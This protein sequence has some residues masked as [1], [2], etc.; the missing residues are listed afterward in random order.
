MTPTSLR[1]PPAMH[2]LRV[3]LPLLVAAGASVRA[4]DRPNFL[5]I[6]ADDCTYSDL[7]LYGGG[8]ARTPNLDRLAAG[9]LTFDRAYVSS[10][11]CQ[12]CRSELYSGQ[13]PLRNGAAWN[14]SASR[15]GTLSLPHFLRPLGYRVGL[16]G[17]S[18]V[19]PKQAFPFDEVPGFDG[20]CVRN[21]TR[22]HELSG[23][24]DYMSPEKHDSPFCLVVALVEPHVPWVMGDASAYPPA[25]LKLPPHLADTPETRDNFSRYLAEVS[26]MDGQLGEIL[27]VLEAS[28]VADDT[29]VLFSSEQG[30]Q[31][32]GCKWTNWEA[33]V[34]TALVARWPGKV[35]TG[36]RSP[37]LVQYADLAP[38][39]VELAG[40]RPAAE[41]F[42]GSSF[43]EVLRGGRE[44]HRDYAYSMHNNLPEG[45]SYP[46]RSL[47]DGRFRYI[48]NLAPEALYVE[49]HVMGPGKEHNSYWHSWLGANPLTQPRVCELARRYMTRP[50]EQ[51]Y[52]LDADP[53]NLH[54][55][56]D[57]KDHAGDKE[58]LSAAL[59]AW[60]ESQRDP[61]APVDTPRALRAARQ[62][63]HLHGIAGPDDD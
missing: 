20:N 2:L 17:K 5:V 18:H 21:P 44:R 6:L 22:P 41:R 51:L 10:A 35:A 45:P 12:P 63:S 7:P 13:F 34:R 36:A 62:G 54:N 43:A 56:A 31:F 61:G 16:A 11:M 55:L 24:R 42:D 47:T 1:P 3:L 9:G 49:K 60:L 57:D 39:L 46:I 58:R 40:G 23:I 14:H 38:T 25:G 8:N 26:Y 4:A 37:A 59:E 28:G 30:A 19:V 53:H 52:R 27:G 29:L 32:P 48:R 33:G 15:P 50:A